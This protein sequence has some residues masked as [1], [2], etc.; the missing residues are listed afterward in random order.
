M[1]VL[2]HMQWFEKFILILVTISILFNSIAI[3]SKL[4]RIIIYGH[5]KSQEMFDI[6]SLAIV[7]ANVLILILMYLPIILGFQKLDVK[8]SIAFLFLMTFNVCYIYGL[9]EMLLFNDYD[10]KHKVI[11]LTVL[12]TAIYEVIFENLG[13]ATILFGIFLFMLLYVV[14][15]SQTINKLMKKFILIFI[16]CLGLAFI[17]LGMNYRSHF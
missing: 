3:T 17:Y 13:S 15:C 9:K 5:G 6:I 7:V 4:K 12:F 14:Y 2:G 16:T 11:I 8:S 1:I 10:L